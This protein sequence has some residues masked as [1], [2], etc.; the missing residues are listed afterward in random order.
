MVCPLSPEKLQDTPKSA[1]FRLSCAD[2]FGHRVGV[3]KT[4]YQFDVCFV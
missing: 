2:L 4:L 1:R 3:P